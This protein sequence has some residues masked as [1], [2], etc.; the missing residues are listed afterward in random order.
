MRTLAL[1]LTLSTLGLGQVHW[2]DTDP[3]RDTVR[4]DPTWRAYMVRQWDTYA[5]ECY[6]DSTLTRV[7]P[8]GRGG[9]VFCTISQTCQFDDHWQ[10]VWIHREPTFPDFIEWLRRK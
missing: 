5:K 10:T 9:N 3:R 6:A 2:P 7:H 1:M 8:G 4:I